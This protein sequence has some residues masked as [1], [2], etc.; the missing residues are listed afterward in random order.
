MEAVLDLFPQAPIYTSVYHDAAVSDRLRAADV[1]TSWLQRLPGVRRY[2][3]ALL[4]LMP[5]AFASFDL[6]EYDV[7][8]S[9]TSAFAKHLTIRGATRHVCFCHT[10]PRY[11]WDLEDEYLAGR[12][13]EGA[14]RSMARH[15]RRMDLEA[16]GTVHQFIA[17]SDTV[18]DRIRRWYGRDSMVIHPPVQTDLFMPVD[19]PTAD[20]YLVV[21]R[22]VGYKR[23]DLAVDACTRLGRKLVVVGEGP[24][25]ARLRRRGGSSVSFVGTKPDGEIARLYANCRA[26]LFPGFD[27]FG[28]APVEAQA[29]GRPVIAYARGGAT[30]TVRDRV[31][32]LFFREQ[33]VSA[34]VE[35]IERFERL[36]LDPTACR[37]NAERF[38]SSVF[39]D[40]LSLVLTAA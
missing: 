9:V 24:E 28:I 12:I 30:E 2:S 15:L 21:S 19:R 31:T 13:G 38:D 16:A 17:N 18:A 25:G 8:L 35:A 27:D 11:L 33:S 37:E 40:R 7:A 29:A 3:R 4:P 6:T 14:L 1:R 22:L 20:Y 10:P 5:T 39:R 32:G 26:L 36:E 34:V 23:I